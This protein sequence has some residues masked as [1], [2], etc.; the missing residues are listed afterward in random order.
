MQ[1]LRT[2]IVLHPTIILHYCCFLAAPLSSFSLVSYFPFVELI[3]STD[4]TMP[5]TMM[6]PAT[7][8]VST[9][10]HRSTLCR[11][12]KSHFPMKLT[13]LCRC[14]HT[15]DYSSTRHRTSPFNLSRSTPEFSALLT[16]K[17]WWQ[18]QNLN[19]LSGTNLPPFLKIQYRMLFVWVVQP[20]LLTTV[21]ISHLRVGLWE[22]S[23]L[24]LHPTVGLLHSLCLL[25]KPSTL[26]SISWCTSQFLVLPCTCRLDI[27]SIFAKAY[28]SSFF[29]KLQFGQLWEI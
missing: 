27:W 19:W 26:I 29:I 16:F 2:H 15:L 11:C 28:S 12:D 1:E 10:S 25:V 8:V 17:W 24:T 4:I 5:R 13:H 3:G 18:V 6:K 9:I 20:Q 7:F 23:K 14:P 22:T 21:A